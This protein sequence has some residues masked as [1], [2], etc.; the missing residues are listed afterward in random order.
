M[1]WRVWSP[2]PTFGTAWRARAPSWQRGTRGMRAPASTSTSIATWKVGMRPRGRR[3]EPGST[4]RFRQTLRSPRQ[5]EVSLPEPLL[6]KA[7]ARQQAVG[8]PLVDRIRDFLHLRVD[9]LELLEEDLLGGPAVLH[10]P[11]GCVLRGKRKVGIE[12]GRQVV[13]GR[14]LDHVEIL[15]TERESGCGRK[16]TED[17]L[18]DLPHLG[19]HIGGCLACHAPDQTIQRRRDKS[20][21]EAGAGDR[22]LPA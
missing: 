13:G 19:R 20:R 21:I 5:A 16:H 9:Q 14:A 15:R 18:L 22:W 3:A 6:E 8:V 10:W 2:T 1:L 11:G 17:L 4:P 7:P 12:G